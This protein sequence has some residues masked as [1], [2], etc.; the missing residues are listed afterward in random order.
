MLRILKGESVDRVVWAPRLEQWFEVNA[1]QKTLPDEF[2]NSEL[3]EICDKLGTSP[4]TYYFF[5]ESIRMIQGGDVE[6]KI[7]EDREKIVSVY[8]TPKGKLHEV[9]KKSIL[10]LASFAVA[11]YWTE[12]M[13]KEADDLNALKYLLENQ[14]YEFD[15]DSYERSLARVGGRG[16]PTIYCPAVPIANLTIRYAGLLKTHILLR[17][18]QKKVEDLLET[19]DDNNQHFLEVLNKSPFQWYCSTITSIATYFHRPYF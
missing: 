11:P 18:N 16:P 8:S 2:R 13:V 1:F 5:E 9:R 4:R 15:R 17:K 10:G 7:T 6:V 14:S 12:H 3:L 19:L